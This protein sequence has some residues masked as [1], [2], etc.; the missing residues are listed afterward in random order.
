MAECTTDSPGTRGWRVGDSRQL[1]VG[2]W[3]GS[4]FSQVPGVYRVAFLE[5]ALLPR[6]S[7]RSP[8]R[9][10]LALDCPAQVLLEL[11]TRPLGPVSAL[12]EVL[13]W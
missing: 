1:Q 9:A 3:P 2:R 11:P 5:G 7:L 12:P 8:T 10:P 13:G 6:A 4:L